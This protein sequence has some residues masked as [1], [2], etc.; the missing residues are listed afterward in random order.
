MRN[1]GVVAVRVLAIIVTAVLA[2]GCS[3][4]INRLK[5]SNQTLVAQREQLTKQVDDLKALNVQN[6]QEIARLQTELQKL[7]ADI[8][9][10][11]GQGEAYGKA[12]DERRKMGDLGMPE[13]LM[14]DLAAKMNGVYLPGGGIRLSSDVLFDS[15]KA[16][17]KAA[18]EAGLKAAGD[19]LSS[20]D[21][22]GL[23]LRID[24]HTDGQPIKYSKW[25][26]NMELSQARAR[27]VWLSLKKD[28]VAAERMFT[29][30]FGEYRPID[31]NTASSGRANNRRVE[32][33]LV[34]APGSVEGA[35][36][37]AEESPAKE[38]T[39][40]ELPEPTK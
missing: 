25:K 18:G 38:A 21:A 33:W 14:R 20:A 5:G 7:Q 23:Y 31:A 30:G 37:A 2:A 1:E 27:S 9:Y 29:A 16:E 22:Q 8:D 15:G 3:A 10:Y 39:P 34:P 36:A 12:Y 35:G 28:G 19:A 6:E 17:L 4:E 11:K 24:G 13:K 26:D 32:I 40:A